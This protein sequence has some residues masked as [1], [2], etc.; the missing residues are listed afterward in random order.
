MKLGRFAITFLFS[1]ALLAQ[2]N[3]GAPQQSPPEK[4]KP[5]VPGST[6]APPPKVTDETAKPMA[7]KEEKPLSE[8]PY[9]PSL[10]LNAMDQSADACTD[11]YQY[12]CGG[13]IAKNPIPPDQASWSVYGKLAQENEQFLWGV[14][15]DAAKPSESRD[16]TQQK[17]GDYFG[18][19]MDEAGIEKLGAAPLRPILD[20]ISALKNRNDLASYLAKEHLRAYGSEFLFAF[21]S[22]Q[23]FADATQVIAS[24]AAGGLGLPDRDYY[25][26]TDDKSKDIR[27]KYVDHVA[28]ML[29]LTGEPKA[30]A[31]RH[32]KAVMDIETALAKASLTRVEQRDPYKLFHKMTPAQLKALAPSFD[33]NRYLGAYHLDKVAT[34]NVTEPAF[35]KEMESRIR[36]VP[37]SDWKAYLRWHAVNARANYLSSAFVTEDFNFYRKYLRGVT[38]QPARWKRCVRLVDRDLGEALGQEFVRRT[39]TPET[40][41][42]T[43]DMTR[44]IEHAMEN[45]IQALDWMTDATKKRALEKLHAI[46]NKVGYPEHWRDYSTVEV[47]RSDFFGN[48]A[49]ATTFESRRQ[50]QKIGKPVDRGEWGMTPPTVNAY[51]NPQMNDINFP[52][53]VLQ[54]PLYDPK[55][56]DAPNYGNTGSTI[57]HEL[58]HAF[59]DEGRQFDAQGNLKDWWTEE[60]AKKFEERVNCV[61]D[62][63]AQYTIVDDIKINSKLTSGEDVAD[64]GGTL[65]AYIAWK[66]ATSAM[67]LESKDGFTPDQR[68]FIGFAQWACNDQRPENLRVSAITNPHSPGRYRVNGIVADLPEFRKAFSCQEGK[69]MVSAKPCRVW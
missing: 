28:R 45:E 50:L 55:L 57:G 30:E 24:A 18:A 44:R 51:Y 20:E 61:R 43:V 4:P 9:T 21:G 29:E 31:A 62:Q 39:F 13:W 34:V 16:A 60:D 10:D 3:P 56:D 5:A 63:Y 7:A 17:I 64:L 53:G 46:A 41:E 11:F 65:L 48:V 12:V 49:N 59:D 27:S 40:K 33:W 42:K 54:P 52:A 36:T 6:A 47:K 2:G 1:S 8:L 58:T 25:T 35:F 66:D 23:D 19:C 38:E 32:A 37:L 26:K 15:E 68:F 69:P 67:K 14:L 22:Q